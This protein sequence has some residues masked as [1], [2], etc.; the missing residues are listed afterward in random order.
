MARERLEG[1]VEL[2]EFSVVVADDCRKY[3]YVVLAA[4]GV[5]EFEPSTWEGPAYD[6]VNDVEVDIVEMHAIDE[7]GD[8]IAG[9]FPEWIRDRAIDEALDL[10]YSGRKTLDTVED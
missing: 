9:D 4:R 1:Q 10:I 8:E 2:D 6:V 7:N 3:F 5:R